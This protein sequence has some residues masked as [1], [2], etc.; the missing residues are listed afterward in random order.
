[1]T[2]SPVSLW[3]TLLQLVNAQGGGGAQF[4]R[5]TCQ[6][7]LGFTKARLRQALDPWLD[8]QYRA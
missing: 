1:L 5:L 7:M 8:Y 3:P 4:A 2:V 6:G